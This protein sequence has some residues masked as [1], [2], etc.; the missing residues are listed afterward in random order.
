MRLTKIRVM[1]DN[2]EHPWSYMDVFTVCGPA[3][4][5]K[6]QPAIDVLV[7]QVHDWAPNATKEK[8]LHVELVDREK[9]EAW[10][11]SREDW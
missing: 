8:P 6:G 5:C 2:P 7:E 10:P 3:R 11:K 9:L 4:S 1:T